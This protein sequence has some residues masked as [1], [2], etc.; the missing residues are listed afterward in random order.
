M[1]NV[2]IEE[3]NI[4][5]CIKMVDHW[6]FETFETNFYCIMVADDIKPILQNNKI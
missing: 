2:Y 3:I 1:L 5:R 6:S 4:L